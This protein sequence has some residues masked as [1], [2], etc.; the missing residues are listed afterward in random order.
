VAVYIPILLVKFFFQFLRYES[1]RKRA[2]RTFRKELR[3]QNMGEEYVEL[4]TK[5]YESVGSLRDFLRNFSGGS[6]LSLTRRG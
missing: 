2:V 5:K 1:R 4:F 3:A 6:L